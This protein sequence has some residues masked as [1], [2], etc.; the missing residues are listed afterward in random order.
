MLGIY[1]RLTSPVLSGILGYA[2]PFNTPTSFESPNP[3]GIHLPIANAPLNYK[4]RQALEK[5]FRR[6]EFGY[7]PR[8]RFDRNGY[9]REEHASHPVN[10]AKERISKRRLFADI[11]AAF[12]AIGVTSNPGL[13]NRIEDIQGANRQKLTDVAIDQ[14]SQ[15][16]NRTQS[17]GFGPAEFAC[18]QRWID[19]ISQDGTFL[20]ALQSWDEKDQAEHGLQECH[21]LVIPSGCKITFVFELVRFSIEFKPSAKEGFS[22]VAL[23]SELGTGVIPF[24]LSCHIEGN[25]VTLSAK[26]SI[27]VSRSQL[28][29]CAFQ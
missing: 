29:G 24:G 16:P 5:F 9:L 27:W 28:T 2:M 22:Q 7:E 25:Q 10:G 26:D 19:S 17:S 4:D 1:Q 23:Q 8:Y 13:N 3:F 11:V 15:L 18:L 14:S 6:F 12:H 20:N 21:Q